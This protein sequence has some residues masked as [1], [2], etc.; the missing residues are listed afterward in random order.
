MHRLQG[1]AGEG[2]DECLDTVDEV[3][4]VIQQLSRSR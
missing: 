4:M 2:P 1:S 3:Q